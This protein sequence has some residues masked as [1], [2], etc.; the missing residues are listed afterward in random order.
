MLFCPKRLILL[1]GGV[2]ISMVVRAQEHSNLRESWIQFNVDTI[3]L[4]TLSVGPDSW[5]MTTSDGVSV[6]TSLYEFDWAHSRILLR[7]KA[8]LDSVKI[9]YLSLIHI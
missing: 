4:D 8:K 7:D 3:A 6:D 5:T 2:L 1:V 9:Q